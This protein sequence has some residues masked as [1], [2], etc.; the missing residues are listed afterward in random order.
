LDAETG[1]H[2]ND[3]PLARAAL[4]VVAPDRL[5]EPFDETPA[6]GISKQR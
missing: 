3:V 1:Q 4:I 2:L 6:R 5:T